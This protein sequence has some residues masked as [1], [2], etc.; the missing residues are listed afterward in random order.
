MPTA[1]PSTVDE[2]IAS[3]PADK[4]AALKALRRAIRAAAPA[5][6]EY[7]GYGIAGYKHRGKSLIYFAHAKHHVALHGGALVKFTKD[8]K[9]YETTKGSVHFD[10]AKPI[11]AQLVARIVKDRAAEIDAAAAPTRAGTRRRSG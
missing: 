9:G 3:A 11:P 10:P 8:V 6:T 1:R 4:R 5:A 2:Y 7:I